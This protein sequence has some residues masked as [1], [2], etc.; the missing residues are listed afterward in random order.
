VQVPCGGR[1]QTLDLTI[2]SLVLYPLCYRCWP[3]QC[4]VS[5]FIACHSVAGGTIFKVKLFN[6]S[7]YFSLNVKEKKL[8]YILFLSYNGS[9]KFLKIINIFSLRHFW[10]YFKVI[11]HVLTISVKHSS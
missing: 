3:N 6:Q 4:K 5:F 11:H 7:D 1:I 2:G 8:E 9:F 10:D